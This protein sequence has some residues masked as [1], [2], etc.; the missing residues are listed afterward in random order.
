VSQ[1]PP[2]ADATAGSPARA[3]LSWEGSTCTGIAMALGTAAGAGS[4]AHIRDVAAAHGQGGWIAYAIAGS[5]DLMAVGSGLEIRRRRRLGHPARWPVF[6]LLLGVAM[7]LAANLATAAPSWWGRVMAVWP[8]V[9]LLAVVGLFETRVRRGRAATGPAAAG[10]LDSGTVADAPSSP[11]TVPEPTTLPAVPANGR[12]AGGTGTGGTA[13]VARMRAHWA[14]RRA[15]GQ[16][17]TGAELARVTGTDPSLGR[18]VRRQLLKDDARAARHGLVVVP[19]DQHPERQ[20][21][22]EVGGAT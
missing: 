19:G 1:V 9:A 13:A 5:V 12:S 20:D 15:A 2:I 14:A 22:E 3:R 21:P 16:T 11:V 18:R 6:T 7:T 4:F 17:P 8:A 10:H